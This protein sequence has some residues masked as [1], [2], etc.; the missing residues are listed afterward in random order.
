MHAAHKCILLF[1]YIYLFVGFRSTLAASLPSH[2]KLL[3]T[4][5]QVLNG[6]LE[7]VDAL[8]GKMIFILSVEE[9]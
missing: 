5:E 9:V 8:I 4:C 1:I 2:F 6:G 3:R 7:E